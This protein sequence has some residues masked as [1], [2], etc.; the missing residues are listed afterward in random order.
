MVSISVIINFHHEGPLVGPTVRAAIH[1]LESVSTKRGVETELIFILDRPDE[2]T[3]QALSEFQDVASFHTVNFGDMSLARNFGASIAIGQLAIIDGDDI[4]GTG[5]LTKAFDVAAGNNK[6]IVHPELSYYF[7]YSLTMSQDT[8]LRHPSMEDADFQLTTLAFLNPWTSSI[9]ADR[10]LFNLVKY[11]PIEKLS[12]IAYEDWTF[13]QEAV[14]RGF[15][16]VIA[17]ETVHFIRSKPS[18]SNLALQSSY[19]PVCYPIAFL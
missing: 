1:E 8:V 9:L 6:F 15:S 10:E 17:N 14:S 7:G 16:H 18:D 13:N 19:N 4:W 2:S 11:R 12:S 5:W 3:A